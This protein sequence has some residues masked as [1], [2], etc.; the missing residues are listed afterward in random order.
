[1]A[2]RIIE[3]DKPLIGVCAGFNNILR[4][5][6][7]EVL[8]DETDKHNHYEPEYRH[9]ITMVK[10]TRLQKL[11]GKETFKV[12]SIHSMIA[13]KELVAPYAT[14]SSYSYDGLVESYEVENKKFII[15]FKWHPELLMDDGYV[16]D[17]FKEFIDCC[18][19][20]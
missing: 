8:L 18:K 1:M 2:K 7:S 20:K 19:T 10:G 5:L 11:I 3:L 15:G 12:N 17:V 16:F 14:I 13:T 6:G 9:D 4:A